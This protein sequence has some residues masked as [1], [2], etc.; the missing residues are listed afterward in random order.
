[1][2]LKEH[3]FNK[4]LIFICSTLIISCN[5]NEN[6]VVEIRQIVIENVDVSKVPNYTVVKN[7]TNLKLS[8]GIYLYNGKPF[9]GYINQKFENDSTKYIG[10]YLDGK[11][12][13]VSK[14]FFPNGMPETE[15]SFRNGKAYG[16]HI[17]YWENGNK[18]FE[19][20]YND[21]KREGLQK[22]W[23][24]SGNRYCELNYVDDNE[25]GMQ[26][27]WR[28]NGKLYINY[29]VKNGIRYGLQKSGLCYTLKDQKIK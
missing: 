24:E 11:Q 22:Q 1:M 15:R 17:G 3:M 21:N 26:K 12:Y 19:F 28:E 23:Y 25:N 29:Q 9:S 16:K 27:A 14:T 13:G 6:N 2:V 20:I 8:N 7:D 4:L 18:K 10:S 5:K